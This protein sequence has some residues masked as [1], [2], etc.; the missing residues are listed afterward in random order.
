[1]RWVGLVCCVGAE[2]GALGVVLVR[3]KGCTVVVEESGGGTCHG[4]GDG[5]GLVLIGEG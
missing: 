1:M 2:L 4:G 3:K 5:G